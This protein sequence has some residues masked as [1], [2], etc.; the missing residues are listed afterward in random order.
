MFEGMLTPKSQSAESFCIFRS[1]GTL[2]QVTTKVLFNANNQPISPQAA[3]DRKAEEQISCSR[4]HSQR[5]QD[6][7]LRPELTAEARRLYQSDDQNTKEA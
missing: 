3:P 5:A 1:G 4:S 2:I 7:L 6:P